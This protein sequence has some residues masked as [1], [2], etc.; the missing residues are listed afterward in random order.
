M[1]DKSGHIKS[2]LR[3]RAPSSRRAEAWAKLP[4]NEKNT[5]DFDP[6]LLGETGYSTLG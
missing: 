6:K 4:L 1:K 3:R 2:R 5:Q